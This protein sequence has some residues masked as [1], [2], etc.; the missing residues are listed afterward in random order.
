MPETNHFR[1]GFDFPNESLSRMRSKTRIS[2]FPKLIRQPNNAPDRI[3]SSLTTT[4][5]TFARPQP[6]LPRKR[7]STLY[8]TWIP[9]STGISG[10]GNFLVDLDAIPPPIQNHDPVFPVHLHGD[11]FAEF[12]LFFGHVRHARPLLPEGSVAAKLELAP[13]GKSRIPRPQ[14]NEVALSVEDLDTVVAPIRNVD[15]PV[16]INGHVGRSIELPFPIP[17]GAE[18]HQEIAIRRELL[19]SV[20]PPVRDVDVAVAVHVDSPRGS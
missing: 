5:E 15:V 19:D 1:H 7:E 9:V 3:D 14:I 17:G 11:G 12:L 4:K 16:G 2:C 8:P 20:V 6:F 13:G 18:R 10:S